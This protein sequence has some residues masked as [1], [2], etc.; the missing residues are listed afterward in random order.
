MN[1]FKA[2]DKF[3]VKGRFLYLTTGQPYFITS[4]D[5]EALYFKNDLH[6]VDS[7]HYAHAVKVNNDTRNNG[8]ETDYYEIEEEWTTAQ[9]IIEAREMN[10]AQGNIFKVAFTFNIGR[11]QGTDYLRELNKMEYFIKREKERLNSLL[12]ESK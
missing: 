5:N 2:G 9:D 8:G 3:Y 12:N 6:C 10:F 11:H 7:I 4:V 1:N